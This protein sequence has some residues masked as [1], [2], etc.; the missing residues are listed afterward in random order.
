M[1][2]P[3][4]KV[5]KV[6]SEHNRTIL[7]DKTAFTVPYGGFDIFSIMHKIKSFI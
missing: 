1:S 6:T 2:N 3:S 4:L 7:D 5:F